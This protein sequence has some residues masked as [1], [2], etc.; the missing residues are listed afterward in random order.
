MDKKTSGSPIFG[1]EGSL[2]FY[3]GLLV[4]HRTGGNMMERIIKGLLAVAFVMPIVIPSPSI[5]QSPIHKELAPTGKLRVALNSATAVLLTRTSDGIV[6]GGVGY[7]LS[8]FISGKL[9]TVVELVAYPE[10]RY[11]HSDFRKER[12]GYWL[13]VKNSV[14]GRQSGLCRRYSSQ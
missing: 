7:S 14:D 3:F 13:W 8:K 5:A 12:M 2:V 11:I 9:G 10:F 1:R 6:T 4:H